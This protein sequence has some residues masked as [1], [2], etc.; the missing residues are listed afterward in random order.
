MR[1]KVLIPQNISPVGVSYL[2]NNGCTVDM[3]CGTNEETMIRQGADCDAVLARTEKLSAAFLASC[4]QLKVIGRHGVGVNNIDLDAVK[5]LGIKITVTPEANGNTVAEHAMMLIASLAKN[6]LFFDKAV[7][8]GNFEYRNKYF[9]SDLK[10]KTLGIIGVGKIGRLLAKKAVYGFE[11]R[12][13]GY[14][15]FVLADKFEEHIAFAPD[16]E[17]IL[18]K[19]DFVSLHLPATK[20]TMKIIGEKEFTLMKPTAFFVNVARGEV[21]DGQALLKALQNKTIK[22][23]AIDV[24]D[25]EPPKEDNP[26]F[27]LDNVILTPHNAALSQEAMDRMAL[28]AAMGIVSVLKGENPLWPLSF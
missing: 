21:V 5:E 8:N 9:V 10:D 14:D 16:I 13:M 2:E 12:A 1:F 25:P 6:T 22:G 15:P 23:A 20:D 3:G 4:K 26:L 11:M 24:F 7:R 17:T 18:R 27:S 19:C 28:H